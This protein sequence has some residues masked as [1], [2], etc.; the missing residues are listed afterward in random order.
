[1]GWIYKRAVWWWPQTNSP[2]WDYIRT[3]HSKR[4]GKSNTINKNGKTTGSDEISTEMLKAL[5]DQ[6]IDEIT[7]LCNIIYN[8]WVIP[9]DLK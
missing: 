6:N 7:N 2:I 4:S 9:S 8:T 3:K 5:D 1:M